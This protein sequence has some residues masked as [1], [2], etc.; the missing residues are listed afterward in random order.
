MIVR[1]LAS[2][3]LV[4]SHL[5]LEISKGLKRFASHQTD[6]SMNLNSK[7]QKHSLPN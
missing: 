6:T 4:F 5:E 3:P 7:N 2:N 1:F